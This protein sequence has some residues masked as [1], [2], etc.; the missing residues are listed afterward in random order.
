MLQ[1]IQTLFLLIACLVVGLLFF[2]PL[3]EIAVGDK[4]FSFTIIGVRDPQNGK[5]LINAWYLL[6]I[7]FDIII[8]QVMTIFFYKK[9]LLQVKLAICNLVLMAALNIVSWFCIKGSIG[10]LGNGIY[11]LKISLILPFI[12][13]ILNY[14]AIRAIKKDEELVR[15]VDRI[16]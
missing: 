14:L 11:S 16:R 13:I 6:T 5:S 12:A 2:L 15:S 3:G 8:I 7:L 10:V 4:I 1:R 9:R